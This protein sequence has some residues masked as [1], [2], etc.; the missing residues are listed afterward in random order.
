MSN[1]VQGQ[2]ALALASFSNPTSTLSVYVD[3]G[4]GQSLF[5]C[6]E[7]FIPSS[8]QSCSIEVEGVSGPLPVHAV[9]TARFLAQCK[10]ET[11]IICL[12]HN[13]LLTNGRHHLLSVSQFLGH[14]LH[15]L[16]FQP[17]PLLSL[18]VSQVSGSRGYVCPLVEHE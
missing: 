3:S 5:S 12:V 11:W 13:A 18:R 17:N 15:D 7:A 4:A 16:S 2:L 14:G 10:D 9:G 6:S 8:L 1:P